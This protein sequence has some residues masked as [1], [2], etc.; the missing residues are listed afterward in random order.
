MTVAISL[1]P[2]VTV[3]H[4]VKST[5]GNRGFCHVDGH[6]VWEACVSAVTAVVHSV[7]YQI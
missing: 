6:P 2:D 4:H 3:C 5:A 7:M 1:K